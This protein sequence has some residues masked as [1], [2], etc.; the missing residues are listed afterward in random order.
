M[1][2]QN[3]PS[4]N[5][6]LTAVPVFEWNYMEKELL[7]LVVYNN[8]EQEILRILLPQNKTPG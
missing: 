2:S 5:D 7:V 8:R 6:T 3:R 4:V 1:I